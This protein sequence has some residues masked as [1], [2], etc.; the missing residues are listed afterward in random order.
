MVFSNKVT[1][2][3]IAKALNVSQSTV[4]RALSGKGRISEAT[5]KRVYDY[6]ED[7][8]FTLSNF[9]NKFA[10]PKNFTIGVVLPAEQNLVELPFFQ[11]VLLGICESAATLDYDVIVITSQ[12]NDISSLVR[13]IDRNKVDGIILTRSLVHDLPAEFLKG[14]NIPFVVI[15]STKEKNITEI[16]NDHQEACRE[17]ISILAMK[18]IRNFGL[19]GGDTEHIVTG[20]RYQGFLEGLAQS[21]IDMDSEMIFTN[22]NSQLL[23]DH[24]VKKLMENNADCIICMDDFL[25]TSVLAVLSNEGYRIPEDIKVASFYNSSY[26]EKYSPPITALN[27]NVK[28]L[29]TTACKALIE[30]IH[31]GISGN[32]ILLNY[33]VVLKQSTK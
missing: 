12:G 6:I 17:L 11:G 33:E 32:K 5:R 8:N 7:H 29:G 23:I 16:D 18:G 31:G 30:E 10:Q 24:A 13:I 22:V 27:F 19:I 2:S 1:I 20:R 28:E 14:K 21:S 15:G 3:D 26:L 9:A 25:C 4:S